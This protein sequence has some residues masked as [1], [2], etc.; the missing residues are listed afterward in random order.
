VEIPTTTTSGAELGVTPLRLRSNQPPRFYRGGRAI[1]DFRGI[2]ASGDHL[3]EDWVA[4]TTTL[5]GEERLGLSALPGGT[6]LRDAVAAA[7]ESWLGAEHTRRFGADPALLVKLLDAGERLPVHCHPDDAFARSHLGCRFGKTESWVVLATRS[8]SAAVHLGFRQEVGMD[9]LAGWVEQQDVGA[10]LGALRRMEVRP[11]DA[12]LVPAG[13]PHS[14]GEGVFV[15]ELQ[16]PTDLSVLMERDGFG[17]PSSHGH[18]GLGYAAALECVDRSG[19]DADRLSTLRRRAGEGRP[20]GPGVELLLP[21]EADRFFRAQRIVPRPEVRLEASFAVLV[22]I[23]GSGTLHTES[24]PSLELV[25]GDTAV[26]PF[27]AGA[28]TLRGGLELVRCLPPA[29]EESAD[30]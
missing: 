3:P 26:V 13:I 23:N 21:S 12:V 10:M 14:I 19:W 20:S 17:I 25:R 9:L 15:V 4:S 16:E 30:G 29:P 8:P 28:L 6:L 18:L 7:P 27:A 2:P 22:I 1:A 11:G 24:G 5:N